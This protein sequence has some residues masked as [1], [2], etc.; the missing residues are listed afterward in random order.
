MPY[1]RGGLLVSQEQSVQDLGLLRDAAEVNQSYFDV[2]I[3]RSKS[4]CACGAT[5]TSISWNWARF[6]G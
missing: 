4:C 1:T 5:R 2:V 3:D 6:Y